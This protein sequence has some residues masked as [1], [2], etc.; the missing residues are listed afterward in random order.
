MPAVSHH[1]AHILWYQ[2][3]LNL[4]VTAL[5]MVP[6]GTF[7]LHQAVLVEPHGRRGH[8]KGHQPTKALPDV[9][10]EWM[11]GRLLVESSA[12][13][14]CSELVKKHAAKPIEEARF[15]GFHKWGYP[16]MDL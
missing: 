13:E 15:G 2:I 14:L 6:C 8:G 7:L 5:P 16:K 10:N 12:L 3:M 1:F 4:A 11:K 9:L